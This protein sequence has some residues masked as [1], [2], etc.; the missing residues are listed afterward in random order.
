MSATFVGY[1]NFG[2]EHNHNVSTG[3]WPVDLGEEIH[4]CPRGA[5][6]LAVGFRSR[7]STACKIRL[8][9]DIAETS[10]AAWL[11]QNHRPTIGNF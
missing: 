10:L 3:C 4:D 7:H 5:A 6:D 9:V 2:V 8:Q 1:L 11:L